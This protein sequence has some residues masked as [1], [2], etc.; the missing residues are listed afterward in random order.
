MHQIQFQYEVFKFTLS[1][2]NSS[3]PVVARL[4]LALFATLLGDDG[5]CVIVEFAGFST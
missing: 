2:E 3:L 1:G 4:S 5:E